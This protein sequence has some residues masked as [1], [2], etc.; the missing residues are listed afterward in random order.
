MSLDLFTM[1]TFTT[2]TFEGIALYF[3]PLFFIASIVGGVVGSLS[4]GAG[5]ITMPL[6]LVSGLNPLQALATNKLQACVGSFVSAAHYYHQGLVDI[7][8][9]IAKADCVASV[10]LFDF[11]FENLAIECEAFLNVFCEQDN[12]VYRLYHS[13]TSFLCLVFMIQ[14]ESKKQT[15]LS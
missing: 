4:G 2:P 11:A 12:M 3:Y 5:M 13:F 8:F 6:L 10:L 14:G 1:A 7:D 15:F 9:L